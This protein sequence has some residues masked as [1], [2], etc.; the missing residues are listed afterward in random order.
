MKDLPFNAKTF[1]LLHGSIFM[2][3][4]Y[5]RRK[6]TN[7][8]CNIIVNFW[9]S[10]DEIVSKSLLRYFMVNIKHVFYEM[11]HL[12]SCR[13]DLRMDKI[14]G[15]DLI[16]RSDYRIWARDCIKLQVTTCTR[17]SVALLVPISWW[18]IF[19]LY[20]KVLKDKT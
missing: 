1:F 16:I 17:R 20:I 18:K 15:S 3:R 7:V 11:F 13:S 10:L 19:W 2:W 14:T 8:K 12:V 6:R 9:P 5:F 4:H